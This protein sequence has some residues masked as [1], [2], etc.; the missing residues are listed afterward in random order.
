MDQQSSLSLLG[1]KGKWSSFKHQ[2]EVVPQTTLPVYV[3]LIVLL[4]VYKLS[5]N[6]VK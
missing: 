2:R 4:K 1:L 5:Y 6:A 3:V